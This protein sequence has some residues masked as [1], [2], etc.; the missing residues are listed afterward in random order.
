MSGVLLAFGALWG[1]PYLM[2]AYDL[3]RT[4]AAG[5]ASMVFL[6]NGV[7]SVLIGAWSDRIRR[8]KLPMFTGVS[9]CVAS[10]LGYLLLPSLPVTVV[11]ALV[12]LSGVGGAS[13][14]LAVATALE[15]NPARHAG[16]TV[17][18]INMAVTGSGALLQPLIGWLLDRAWDG[19]LVDGARVY[20]AA[21]YRVA[22]MVVPLLGLLAIAVLAAIRE[23]HGRR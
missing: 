21:D 18:I 22:L 13:M 17:G 3:G 1:V 19:T 5:I 16:L 7:G 4:E 20:A 14:V 12:F 11:T 8:R 10:T 6:G 9:L 23:T 15:Q 2:S